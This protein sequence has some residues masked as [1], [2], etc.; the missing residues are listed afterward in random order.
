MMEG[1]GLQAL[2]AQNVDADW[3]CDRFL[4]GQKKLTEADI[5]H[6]QVHEQALGNVCAAMVKAHT[7]FGLYYTNS[8]LEK[9]HRQCN[10]LLP[11]NSS[12]LLREV[13]KFLVDNLW[14]ECQLEELFE[15]LQEQ[16]EQEGPERFRE[17]GAALAAL[18]L[19]NLNDFTKAQ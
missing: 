17:I 12:P 7:K 5:Q 8:D 15:D 9:L 18:F 13:A 3:V 16:G 6:L 11:P 4:E 1:E 2:V 14:Q 19:K 10:K